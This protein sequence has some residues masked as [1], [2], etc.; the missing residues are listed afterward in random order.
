[1]PISDSS[2][3][4]TR[5]WFR[6]P[7]EF[8]TRWHP[9]EG[10]AAF[11]LTIAACGIIYL[12]S[13]FW[14]LGLD[15][16]IFA[17][18]GSLLLSGKKPY[19][20]MWDV[21]PPN[22]YY[23]NA[24]FEWLFGPHDIT[25]RIADYLF[26]LASCSV[27]FLLVKRHLTSFSTS[28]VAIRLAPP[29]ASL[30]LSLTF[31][32]LG[33][34]DTA[35][36][37]SFAIFFLLLAAA[38][39]VGKSYRPSALLFAGAAIGIATFFKTT[40]AIFLAPIVIELL[41][42]NRKHSIRPIATLLTGWTAWCALQLAVLALEGSLSEYLRITSSVFQH[43]PGEVST[44]TISGLFRS[45]WTLA[46]LWCLL[47]I[48]AIV[49]SLIK[50]DLLFLR[51]LRLPLFYLLAGM[52]AV[53][54]QNKGWGYHYVI[55]LPG[56]LWL[57][58]ISATYL[59]HMVSSGSSSPRVRS[60][61]LPLVGLLA[62]STILITPSAR[63][64][65]HHIRDAY[66]SLKSH[67]S[68]L[69]SLGALQSLYYPAATEQLAAY[70][71]S[72]TGHEDRIFILGEEPGA[73]WKADRQPASH[74]IYALLFTS[75]V[76]SNDELTAMNDTLVKSKPKLIIVERFDTTWFR[77]R[78]ETSESLLQS[79]SLF[80]PLRNLL[81]TDYRIAD[82]IGGKFIAYRRLGS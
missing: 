6:I 17:E 35:Q 13:L 58:A 76:I 21:K 20:D 2:I 9:F 50:R 49:C 61:A 39:I 65:Q 51:T 4:S 66:L 28:A 11:A 30:L 29:V 44:L 73:Y 7:E 1:M 53:Y 23:I 24:L 3:P 16:N 81:H 18:I 43:H 5:G 75:G 62:L 47:S 27:L 55:V 10:G 69:Q 80:S 19:L 68:Y 32:S 63:R 34:A 40:N 59:F 26:S 38:L 33:L 57:C 45:V 48:I 74:F 36:T 22:I 70:L 46:D 67:Q 77:R 12:P 54:L 31:L 52:L 25:V 15:Q 82:T 79:D 64:R 41:I 56:L 42:A 37:E 60:V 8:R 78:P 14:A 71:R 72:N